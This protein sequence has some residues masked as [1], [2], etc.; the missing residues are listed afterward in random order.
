L[1][2]TAQQ[3]NWYQVIYLNGQGWVSGDYL[4]PADNC[5]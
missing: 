3:G 2:A 4:T 1:Q 5:G